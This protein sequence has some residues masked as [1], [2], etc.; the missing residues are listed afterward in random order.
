MHWCGG[1]IIVASPCAEVGEHSERVL[2]MDQDDY[3]R[4]HTKIVGTKVDK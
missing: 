3:K 2:I 1:E 4:T